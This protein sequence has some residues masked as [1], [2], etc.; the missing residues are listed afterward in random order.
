MVVSTGVTL[1]IQRAT[2]KQLDARN[3]N[4]ARDS[5]CR[6][7]L[8]QLMPG[9]VGTREGGCQGQGTQLGKHSG[10]VEGCRVAPL[11]QFSNLFACL[12][13]PVGFLI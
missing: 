12:N 11:L 9:M 7:R 10:L 5:G 13:R 3:A 2:V 1:F 8:R 6:G 4:D